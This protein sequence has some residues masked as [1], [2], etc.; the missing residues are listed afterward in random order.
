MINVNKKSIYALIGLNIIIIALFSFNNIE[1]NSQNLNK[2][3]FSEINNPNS[4][5]ISNGIGENF[6]LPESMYTDIS[7]ITYICLIFISL[8]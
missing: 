8:H 4:L 7:N 5:K 2:D 3:N 1:Y 6:D